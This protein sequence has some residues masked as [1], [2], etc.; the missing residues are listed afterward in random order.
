MTAPI[1]VILVDDHRVL[2]QGLTLVLDTTPD[3]RLLG[4]GASVADADRLAALHAPDVAVVDFRLP[5]GTGADATRRIRRRVRGA[6]VLVLSADTADEAV[7]AALEAGACGYLPK[8]TDAEEVV[9]AIRRAASGETILPAGAME[10][11]LGRQR[12][13]LLEQ[14]ERTRMDAELTPRERE[15]LALMAEGFDNRAIAARLAIGHSTVRGHVQHIIEKL[16]AHSK[17]AAVV[18]A[19]QLGL[20]ER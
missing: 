1:G 19:G 17:L 12:A 3:I 15:V 14:Q 11:L 5:D 6:A 9:E 8:T 16:G 20:L 2:V 13:R 4:V 10:R 18:R 7:L